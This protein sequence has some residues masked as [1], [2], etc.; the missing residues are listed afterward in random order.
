MD[1]PSAVGATKALAI[2]LVLACAAVDW[3][4]RRIPNFLTLPAI[5]LG[6]ALN[7]LFAGAAGVVFSVFGLV[8][9]AGL[10]FIPYFLGGMGAGDVK[11]M[12]AVGALL[13]WQLALAALFYTALAG[14]GI[15]VMAILRTKAFR[16][17][18]SRIGA[19]FRILFA[20]KRVPAADSLE[21]ESVKIPYAVAIAVGTVAALL[22]GWPA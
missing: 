21:G 10:F 18:F 20:S 1:P 13:G 11:L 19:M 9:G 6:L 22:I 2:A 16:S 5:A 4:S 17:S 7:W 3:R 12:G 14:G 15:A 8:V